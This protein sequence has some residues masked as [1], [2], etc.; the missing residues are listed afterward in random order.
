MASKAQR[1][2]TIVPGI[3]S[4]KEEKEERRAG[5][6][7]C[8]PLVLFSFFSFLFYFINQ[9]DLSVPSSLRLCVFV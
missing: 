5:R 3:G 7:A 9:H 8:D 1:P 4:K 2:S 6:R